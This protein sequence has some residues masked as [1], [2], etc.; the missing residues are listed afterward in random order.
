MFII[1]RSYDDMKNGK[2]HKTLKQIIRMSKLYCVSQ[3]QF[4]DVHA[5]KQ[6]GSL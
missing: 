3:I 6:E 5:F 1:G 2:G 4:L